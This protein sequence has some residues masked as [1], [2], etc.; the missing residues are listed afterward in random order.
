MWGSLLPSNLEVNLLSAIPLHIGSSPVS[1]GDMRHCVSA[2]KTCTPGHRAQRLHDLTPARLPGQG[3]LG[4]SWSLASR[5]RLTPCS[6]ACWHCHVLG[7]TKNVSFLLLSLT[8]GLE[9]HST[10]DH[11]HIEPRVLWA[12]CKPTYIWLRGCS[13]RAAW[14]GPPQRR[15]LMTPAPRPGQTRSR[16][17]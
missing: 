17:A 1:V 2:E 4:A 12:A 5:A 6:W 14:G 8:Q 13:R 10:L 15:S 7:N 3:V 16:W 11:K 9:I